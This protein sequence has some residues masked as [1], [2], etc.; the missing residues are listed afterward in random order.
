ME[1]SPAQSLSVWTT[2][3]LIASSSPQKIERDQISHLGLPLGKMCCCRPMDVV[4]RAL[5]RRRARRLRATLRHDRM[6]MDDRPG[7]VLFFSPPGASRWP[8]GWGGRGGEGAERRGVEE[9]DASV[10]RGRKCSRERARA[11]APQF[12]FIDNV[13]DFP[14]VA[15]N[16]KVVGAGDTV[17]TGRMGAWSEV[18]IKSPNASTD[19]ALSTF[20]CLMGPA[21]V[22]NRGGSAVTIHRRGW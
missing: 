2:K 19:S 5:K 1:R 7:R 8:R 10:H 4:D 22:E 21:S 20:P 13:C 14:T 17:D 18:G 3:C 6:T 9:E 11:E 16:R 15:R 12:L